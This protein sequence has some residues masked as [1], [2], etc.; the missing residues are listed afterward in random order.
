ME[1]VCCHRKEKKIMLLELKEKIQKEYDMFLEELM[2]T[3][4]VNYVIDTAYRLVW[5]QEIL[6]MFREMQ[7][8]N[9]PLSNPQIEFLKGMKNALDYLYSL[10]MKSDNSFIDEFSETILNELNYEG[11]KDYEGK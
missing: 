3:C 9:K 2:T 10:W 4:S 7:E 5:S 11:G 1:N 6:C 8:E